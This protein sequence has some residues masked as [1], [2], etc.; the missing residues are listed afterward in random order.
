VQLP[1]TVR[2]WIEERANGVRF[3]DLREAARALSSA[4]REGRPPDLRSR[5]QVAA[6]LAT[7]M[8][9]TY[10]A[11]HAVLSEVRLRLRDA[12]I[13]SVLDIG[14]GTGAAALAARQCFGLNRITLIERNAAL[15]AAAR[16]ILPDAEM[17]SEDFTRIEPFPPHDL[18]I[19]GYALGESPSAAVLPRLWQAARRALVV[20]E[21][22]SRGGFTLLREIRSRLLAAGAR[23]LAPCPAEGPCGMA[24]PDWCHFA[25][26]VERS[27]LHR[28]LKEA[29]LSYEDE[30]YSY[31]AVTREPAVPAEARVVRRPRQQP[32]L[33]LL[34]T[35]TPQ[36]L[37][38]VRVTQRD[39]ER[40]RAARRAAWGAEWAQPV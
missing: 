23:M 31:V 11:A 22:G 5:E 2:E 40:F 37:E 26:R 39:R 25:A 17:R 8:P 3:A 1:E 24:E 35:C 20:L 29:E 19:A 16:E 30:K 27:S 13:E 14:A 10:A 32:G 28:R 21:P 36:G 9:A 18:V 34:E 4:Y 38:T 6:Y 15:R 12:R 7:R 33:I